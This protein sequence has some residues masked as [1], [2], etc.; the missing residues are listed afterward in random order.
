M[1][2]SAQVFRSSPVSPANSIAVSAHPASLSKGR[3]TVSQRV[4]SDRTVQSV[5]FAAPAAGKRLFNV[6]V[7]ELKQQQ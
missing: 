2:N 3:T 4:A 1:V 5:L 7:N 6:N